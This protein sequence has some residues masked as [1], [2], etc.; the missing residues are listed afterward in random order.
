MGCARLL[1][2]I[3][4]VE[5][6]ERAYAEGGDGATRS[7]PDWTGLTTFLFFRQTQMIG[8]SLC[9]FCSRMKRGLLYT[10]CQEHKCVSLFLSCV[11]CAGLRRFH[12]TR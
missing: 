11:P 9:A 3:A 2:S 7:I 6:K 4:G 12:D 10:C 5:K 1:T 8:D